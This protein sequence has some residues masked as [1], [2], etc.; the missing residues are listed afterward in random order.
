M[1]ITMACFTGAA[2]MK[3]RHEGCKGV[4]AGGPEPGDLCQCPCHGER[5]ADNRAGRGTV[6]KS[7]AEDR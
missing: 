4:V 3:P 1:R 5:D 2:Y 7:E 6:S